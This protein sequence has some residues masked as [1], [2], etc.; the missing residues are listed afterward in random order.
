MTTVEE[1]EVI[2]AGSIGQGLIRPPVGKRTLVARLI[3]SLRDDVR[4]QADRWPLW[5]SVC[6]GAGCAAYF[7]LKDEPET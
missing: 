4:A 5:S 1:G 7:M 2:E 3:D 6:F